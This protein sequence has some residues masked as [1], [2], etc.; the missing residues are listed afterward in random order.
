MLVRSEESEISNSQAAACGINDTHHSYDN[1]IS[2][3]ILLIFSFILIF[4]HKLT[5]ISHKKKLFD[6]T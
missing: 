1:E 4:F 6:I 5:A 2:R 3:R